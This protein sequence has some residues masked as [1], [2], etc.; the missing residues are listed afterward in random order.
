[1]HYIER[2]IE[3]EIV[4]RLFSG[5]INIIYGPRQ[6][7]KTTLVHHIVESQKINALWLDADM[8]DV[9]EQISRMT[10][11]KWRNLIGGRNMVVIDEA[12]R[13]EDIGLALKILI[14]NVENVR[15]VVTGSSAFDLRNRTDEPL[16]GRKFEYVLLPP[17][18]RELNGEDF[19]GGRRSLDARLVY[20]SYPGV[21]A[22]DGDRERILTSLA[23]SYLYK[24]VLAIDG[25]AKSSALDKLIR[26]LAFQ[27]GQE[28]SYQE[29]G[30]TVGIDRKTAEKYVDILKRSF[31]VFEL[32]AYARN[33]RNEIRKSRKIYFHDTGIR[34]AVI[35]NLLPLESR[36]PEEVGHLFE[37]YLIAERFKMNVNRP[38]PPRMF[39]WRTRTQQEID[40]IEESAE[41]LAAWEM[42]WNAKKAKGT[43]PASFRAAYPDVQTG[44]VSTANI[45]EFLR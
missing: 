4:K 19:L 40:Y 15:V 12:Q 16:T 23:S 21:L 38:V 2:K 5:K 6:S 7:G 44:F 45:E 31:V 17:S 13:I 29:L 27:I 26:A 14:D 32:P 9:R 18:Y 25:I 20:G 1:M 33:L 22:A 34:N 3:S 39:F 42:K 24:D 11:E 41:G 36:S 35:G 8:L 37:N 30:D 10:P 43:L 28:V